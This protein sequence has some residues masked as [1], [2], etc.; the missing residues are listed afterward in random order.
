[1]SV[2]EAFGEIVGATTRHMLANEQGVLQSADPEY[3]HQMRVAVRRLRSALSVFPRTAA[4]VSPR[5]EAKWLASVLGEVRDWDVLV[6]ETFREIEE[7][8]YE[9]PLPFDARDEIARRR[10]AARRKAKRALKSAR[11]RK[12]TEALS[13]L[14]LDDAA[15]E[16][17]IYAREALHDRHE[18]V[19]KRGHDIEAQTEAELHR[20]RIATKKLRYTV[21]FFGSLF[22]AHAVKTYRRKLA[23]LQDVLGVLNDAAT[24]HA[25]AQKAFGD[26]TAPPLVEARATLIGWSNG[27]LH[28]LRRD[29]KRHW[30]SFEKTDKFW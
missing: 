11:Y 22:D 19:E 1:M 21:E 27:R 2:R 16:V 12:L 20:L 6:E 28:T 18:K 26:A 17:V 14:G 13:T 9:T 3:V 23:S 5:R 15:G 24:T 29:L 10:A 25:L 30:K 8:P 7:P 4:E